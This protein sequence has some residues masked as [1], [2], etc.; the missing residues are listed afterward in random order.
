[1]LEALFTAHEEMRPVF[2]LQEELRRLAGK[3]KREFT[4]KVLDPECLQRSRITWPTDLESR[5]SRFPAKKNATPPIYSPYP[6]ASSKS[7]SAAFPERSKELERS[8]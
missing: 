7:S 8:Y 4:P 2:E 5:Y 3:P 6:I 1:M